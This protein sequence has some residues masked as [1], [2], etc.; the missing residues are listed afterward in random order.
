MGLPP[1][2]P[3]SV[4]EV[5]GRVVAS[6]GGGPPEVQEQARCTF[7]DSGETW[8]RENYDRMVCLAAAAPALF[9]PA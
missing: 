3:G 6:P 7:A 2:A 8:G 5:L 1:P 4:V 9:S